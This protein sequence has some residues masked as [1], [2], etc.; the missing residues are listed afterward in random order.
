MPPKIV[1]ATKSHKETLHSKVKKDKA[2]PKQARSAYT[3]Y[4][5]EAHAK[6][7]A[8]DP[9]SSFGEVSKLISLQWKEMNDNTKAKYVAMSE[10][11]KQR[12]VSEKD[13][14]VPTQGFGVDGK[15]LAVG[16]GGKMKRAKKDK[17]LPKGALSSYIIFC[18][19]M[20]SVIKAENPEIANTDIMK[21]TGERW[22]AMSSEQKHPWEALATQ[23]KQRYDEE[24]TAYNANL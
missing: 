19:Q 22:R 23:D 6:I 5:E 9:G 1:K 18:T 8:Q 12:Y 3:F 24:M 2:A 14:Y 7:K 17:N 15:A 10:K 16:K 4:L 21:Q 11:D 13:T 20:R